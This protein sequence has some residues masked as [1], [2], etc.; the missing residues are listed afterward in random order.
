MSADF[1]SW[2]R[3]PDDSAAGVRGSWALLLLVVE[4]LLRSLGE[5]GNVRFQGMLEDHEKLLPGDG[6]D[7]PPRVA[8]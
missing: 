6:G 8:H 3:P 1:T 2:A 7:G 4:V 5:M